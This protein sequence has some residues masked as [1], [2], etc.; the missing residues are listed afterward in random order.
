MAGW[1]LIAYVGTG[2]CVG[3]AIDAKVTLK[4]QARCL[5]APPPQRAVVH[6]GHNVG[7]EKLQE[8]TRAR[9]IQAGSSGT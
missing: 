3:H 8:A 7:P 9:L 2:A 1:T 4:S 6:F 5:G